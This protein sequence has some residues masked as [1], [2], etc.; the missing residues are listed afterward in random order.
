MGYNHDVS[1]VGRAQINMAHDNNNLKISVDEAARVENQGKLRLL[2]SKKLSLVVDLDQTIIHA[3]VVPTVAEWQKDPDNPNFEAVKDVQ[4][5]KLD[6]EVPGGRGCWYYIKLRPG[7]QE[8][9]QKVSQLYELHIYTMGTRAYASHIARIVDPDRK[10]F[11]DRILSRDESGSMTAKSLQRLFPVDT[12]MVV[13]I[14]DRGDVWKWSDNLV[15]VNP[16][17][18]FVGI[19]DINSSFLPKKVEMQTS[20][21]SSNTSSSDSG[22]VVMTGTDAEKEDGSKETTQ[23]TITQTAT[24]T[25]TTDDTTSSSDVSTLEQLVSMGAGD[26]PSLLKEQATQQDQTLT[27]QVEE[28]PLLQ[29]QKRLDAAEEQASG[30]VSQEKSS[31]AGTMDVEGS[32]TTPDSGPSRQNL[33][34]DDDTELEYLERSL[35]K[36]HRAFYEEYEA[37]ISI[38]KSDRVQ[39]LRGVRSNKLSSAAQDEIAI[40]MVPDVKTIMNCMKL[41]VLNDVVLVLSGVVPLGMDIQRYEHIPNWKHPL[42]YFNG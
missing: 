14:D 37:R 19:G 28:R 22:D 32:T 21:K 5:F 36:I 42:K 30:D 8:F 31:P 33:L 20:P 18:F 13:I 29:Q 10:L 41:S 24:T 35:A 11:G 40:E 17:D 15:R 9:L 6:D 39:K 1:N 27:A 3:T 38:T 23:N 16:Y 25:S 12:K 26:N 34:H 4:Q 7:L 2:R